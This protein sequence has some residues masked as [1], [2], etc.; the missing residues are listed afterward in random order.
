MISFQ[1]RAD[2]LGRILPH[3]LLA[4][5]VVLCFHGVVGT[6]FL[7]DDFYLVQRLS[8]EGFFF[9]WGGAGGSGFV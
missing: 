2:G 7:S 6:G 3:I 4:V 9:S 5:A 8:D 1:A